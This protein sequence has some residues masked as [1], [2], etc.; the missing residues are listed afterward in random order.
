MPLASGLIDEGADILT[1][2]APEAQEGLYRREH[3]GDMFQNEA[4]RHATDEQAA[5]HDFAAARAPSLGVVMLEAETVADP[6][7]LLTPLTELY[8]VVFVS[9][10][11]N[12]DI[13]EAARTAGAVVVKMR[14]EGQTPP[15]RCRNA[16]FR[17]LRKIADDLDYVL[18]LDGTMHLSEDWLAEALSFMERRPEVAVVD[19]NTNP[20]LQ[21]YPVDQRIR[22][23]NDFEMRTTESDNLLIRV[24]G[25]VDIGGFRGD[26]IVSDVDDFCLR[27][28]GRGRHIWHLKMPMG[29][30]VPQPSGL[31][32]WW[33]RA[34]QNGFRY[35]YAAAL[36]GGPPERFRILEMRRALLWG[37][38]FPILVVLLAGAVTALAYYFFL[39]EAWW[40]PGIVILG[41]GV[42]T[43]LIKS[44]AIT[45]QT[46]EGYKLGLI[47]S[48][49]ATLAHFPEMLGILK[50]RRWRSRRNNSAAQ[51]EL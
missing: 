44:L 41:L 50:F 24:T 45:T 5:T 15:A 28:R 33:Q 40:L 26:L 9:Y 4:G 48:I 27:I 35:A 22:Y 20:D 21:R 25:F 1:A 29:N 18:F 47:D 17:Q 12:V 16:G 23:A 32:H 36:H 43:Y 39:M 3:Y 13:A 8:P 2:S 46:I 49:K 14:A 6:T 37:A 31:K 51:G 42:L 7:P 38:G 19:G 11:G 30:A 34:K 10:T